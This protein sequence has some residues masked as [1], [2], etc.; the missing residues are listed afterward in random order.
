[1]DIWYLLPCKEQE[2]QKTLDSCRN[3][4]S[5]TALRNAFILT[6]DR[7]CRYQGAWHLVKKIVFPANIVLESEN[8]TILREELAQYKEIQA[9]AQTVLKINPKEEKFLKILCGN[10]NHIRMSRG[11]ICNGVT[12]VTQGPLKGMEARICKIDR[13]KRLAKLRTE[14]GQNSRYIP[15]GLEIVEKTI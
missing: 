9:Q 3:Y 4:L 13:H 1:M 8:E 15:A 2:E 7:M 6:Y 11:V 5:E 10:R 12:Q 14:D